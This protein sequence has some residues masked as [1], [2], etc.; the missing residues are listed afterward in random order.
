MPLP[1]LLVGAA[2]V[3]SGGTGVAGGAG[4]VSKLRRARRVHDD[5]VER[6]ETHH[7]IFVAE[8]ESAEETLADYGEAKLEAMAGPMNAFVDAFSRLKH[9][10]FDPEV[11]DDEF[12]IDNADLG[13]LR[14]V[15]MEPWI[16]AKRTVVGA[17]AGYAAGAAVGGLAQLAVG[18]LAAASTGT[19]I[20]GLSGAAAT[21]ATLA[22]LGGGAISAGGGGVAAGT[23]VLS[24][25]AIAPAL[26]VGGA[27]LWNRGGKALKDAEANEAEVKEAIAKM[28]SARQ[29]F[30]S[31]TNL[32]MRARHILQTL[33]RRL[34]ERTRAIETITQRE[35]DYRQLSHAEQATVAEAAGLAKTIRVLVDLPLVNERGN[36]KTSSRQTIND[37]GAKLGE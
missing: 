36:V 13:E 15:D 35:T 21:N 26:F 5:A 16:A 8:Q 34:E 31:I 11:T 12:P 33:S 9:V 17:G 7:E 32:A 20:S 4:G 37:L 23:M 27:L 25:V 28:R 3:L 2:I 1:L 24:G 22:W 6:Y 30:S 29:R 10:N 19:A 18:S 14:D